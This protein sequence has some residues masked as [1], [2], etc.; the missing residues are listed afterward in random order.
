MRIIKYNKGTKSDSSGESTTYNIDEQLAQQTSVANT[1][2][3]NIVSG[4]ETSLQEEIAQKVDVTD[5][6]TKTET[7]DLI[8]G[9][10][11]DT[12]TELEPLNI[13]TNQIILRNN[14]DSYFKYDVIATNNYNTYL[15]QVES[16]QL[17]EITQVGNGYGSS[18]LLAGA[19]YSSDTTTDNTTAV[20]S[21]YNNA[22][23]RKVIGTCR[24][25]VPTGAVTL[26]ITTHKNNTLTV[27]T[28]EFSRLGEVEDR[29]N[30]SVVPYN[31]WFDPYYNGQYAFDGTNYYLAVNG[32]WVKITNNT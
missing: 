2:A 32:S 22:D 6:Y 25:I 18:T 1:V 30:N 31:E 8:S 10:C 23:S 21:A 19:Y 11:E 13:Q 24:E 7:D 15:Y 17:I 20:A 14:Y 9:I 4:V 16:G 12:I 3:T 27:K 29:L 26:A 5:V 28:L